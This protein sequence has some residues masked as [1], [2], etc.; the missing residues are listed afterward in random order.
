M[1]SFF[2]RRKASSVAS[3]SDHSLRR[4][5]AS[6][7]ASPGPTLP[8][9]NESRP[10]Q[11]SPA[12][13]STPQARLAALRASM[14]LAPDF[15][16]RLLDVPDGVPTGC[17][18][19]SEA[20]AIHRQLGQEGQMSTVYQARRH[21]D[22]ANVVLKVLNLEMIRESERALL[23]AC[24]EVG[25]LRTI[26]PHMH[27]SRLHAILCTPTQ[28][29]LTFDAIDTDLLSHIEEHGGR[30]QEKD[31]RLLFRQVATAVAHLHGLGWAHRDLKPE[32]V[33]LARTGS[34]PSSS[35]CCRLVDFGEAAR[36]VIGEAS[37]S[38]FR[39]TP[40]YMAPEVAAWYRGQSSRGAHAPPM[41][42][43][44]C[45][46]WSLGVTLYVMLSG[47]SPWNQVRPH[48]TSD[49]CAGGVSRTLRLQI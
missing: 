41:Y 23:K 10:A 6:V 33:G 27:I 47:E 12:Q 5:A 16:A 30:L 44:E 40:L 7:P 1:S 13:P 38:G 21:S 11:S 29:A 48:S 22:D 14:R 24:A 49:I 17:G 26:A 28:I 39:G 8:G 4:A 15:V 46:V 9:S 32:H 3:P 36:C 20:V 43:V 25:A 2:R 18:H 37:L 19:L 34:G 45:D 42:G 35:W 31:G